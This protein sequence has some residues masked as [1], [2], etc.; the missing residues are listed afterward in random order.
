M[1]SIHRLARTFVL[2]VV[3]FV[4]LAIPAFGADVVKLKDGRVFEGTIVREEFG[5]VWIRTNKDGLQREEMFSIEKDVS[6]I[7]RDAASAPAAEATPPSVAE[8]DDYTDAPKKPGEVRGAVLTLGDRANN[9]VGTY[10]VASVL[11]EAIPILEKEIG[12]DRTG[13]VVMRI[14]S[15]GGYGVEVQRISDVVH[16]EYKPRWRTVAWIDT[17][18]SAAAMSA[19]VFEEIYFTTNGNYGACTGFYGSLDKPVEGWELE[20]ALVQMEKISVRGGYDKLIMRAMQIQQPL[21]ATVLPSGEVKWYGDATSGE[22]VVNREREILTFDHILADKVKFSK[23]TAD[24]MDQLQ[25]AMGIKEINWVGKKVPGY[26]WPISK[27]ERRQMEFR[28]KT[29]VDEKNLGNWFNLF[30]TNIGVAASLPRDQRGPYLSKAKSYLDRIRSMIKNNPNFALFQWG[31]P[32]EF[33]EWLKEQEKII[34][35]LSRK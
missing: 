4:G 33:E 5:Y 17:A 16:L 26:P 13:V 23:G 31:G 19:H 14:C 12:T 28:E 22:I 15:G 35:D 29:A 7:T 32:K 21:S 20:K 34:S 25:K 27:A 30:Q 24:T 3:A 8:A 1:R 2:A 6:E 9:M 10:M 11:K 18:I